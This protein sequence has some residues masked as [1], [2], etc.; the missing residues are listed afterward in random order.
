MPTKENEITLLLRARREGR[1]HPILFGAC[2]SIP[3]GAEARQCRARQSLDRE[4]SRME[5]S[6]YSESAT[7]LMLPTER[8]PITDLPCFIDDDGVEAEVMPLEADQ[9]AECAALSKSLNSPSWR[10][11][12]ASHKRVHRTAR[13]SGKVWVFAFRSCLTLTGLVV[14]YGTA[15]V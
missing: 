5:T 15:S 13:E 2:E 12:S 11:A 7:N 8:R 3:R 4:L 10:G 6:R 9:F 14:A 1:R